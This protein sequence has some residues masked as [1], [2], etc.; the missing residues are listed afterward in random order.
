[1]RGAV[2]EFVIT[3]TEKGSPVTAHTLLGGPATKLGFIVFES[4]GK[5]AKYME[6]SSGKLSKTEAL[7]KLE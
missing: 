2:R 5:S 1:M 4:D 6:L 3:I 7:K